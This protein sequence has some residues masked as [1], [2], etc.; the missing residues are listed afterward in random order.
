MG[1]YLCGHVAS[2]PN[3]RNVQRDTGS[4]VA[5]LESDHENE[6]LL[7]ASPLAEMAIKSIA[8]MLELAPTLLR[9][10][11]KYIVLL[12]PVAFYKDQ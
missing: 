9:S 7:D 10:H 2:V 12:R 5:V 11:A 4:I 8:F 3:T 1:C 6:Q